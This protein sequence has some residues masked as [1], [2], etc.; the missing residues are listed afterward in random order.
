MWCGHPDAFAVPADRERLDRHRRRTHRVE[1]RPQQ[2]HQLR[3]CTFR[4]NTVDAD[5]DVRGRVDQTGEGPCIAAQPLWDAGE[6]E[7]VALG[8]KAVP[9]ARRN[10]DVAHHRLADA[11]PL[12]QHQLSADE[13]AGPVRTDDHAGVIAT[14]CGLD[15]HSIRLA[16]ELQQLL[17]LAH[18]DTALAAG[19]H[20]RVIEGVTAHDAAEL[21]RRPVLGR[22][23]GSRLSGGG[24]PP[25]F[26]IVDR[27]AGNIDARPTDDRVRYRQ[28]HVELAQARQGV[29]NEAAGTHL[30]AGVASLLEQHGL[31]GELRGLLVQEQRGCRAGRTATDDDQR[32]AFHHAT[33]LGFEF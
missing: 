18:L 25:T 19:Q 4:L 10:R 2:S 21:R 15:A 17:L 32:P 9:P 20:Q 22:P 11:L 16:P 31:T 33:V 13:T 30:G 28:R 8:G 5:V 12:P 6:A 3:A 14:A 27:P 1:L 23:A 24:A 26:L 7:V 29:R